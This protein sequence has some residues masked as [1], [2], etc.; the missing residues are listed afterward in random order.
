MKL[1]FMSV[2]A[3]STVCVGCG[4]PSHSD[5]PPASAAT[6]TSTPAAGNDSTKSG[7]CP[8]TGLWA[9]CS[10]ETR[11]SQSGFVVRRV[12]DS[13][14]RRTGFSVTPIAYLL[15]R[16]R[17]DVFLYPTTDAV[18]REINGLDTAL[19]GPKG[20]PNQ[21]GVGVHPTFVRSANL[22][23]VYLTD[24]PTQSERLSLALGAGAPQP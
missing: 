10:V 15:G 9:Q 12:P 21:W 6:S 20:R 4:G 17:L 22:I 24:N 19:A 3:A 23:A 14:R 18:A 8:R 1:I 7:T 13:T 2:V 16:N 5:Q 11:L